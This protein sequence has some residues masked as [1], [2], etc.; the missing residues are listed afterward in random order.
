MRLHGSLQGR[1]GCWDHALAKEWAYLRALHSLAE[2]PQFYPAVKLRAMESCTERANTPS[3]AQ[4]SA[5]LTRFCR[6]YRAPAP[7]IQPA[8]GTLYD[9]A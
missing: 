1:N 8:I 5:I 4:F 9:V 3:F 6:V 2:I 7:R